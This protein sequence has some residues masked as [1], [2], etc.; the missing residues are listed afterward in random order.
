[1][2]LLFEILTSEVF[3]TAIGA[4][5]TTAAVFIALWPTIRERWTC[6]KLSIAEFE[7]GIMSGDPRYSHIA[8]QVRFGE[9]KNFA[10]YCTG[11]IPF[12]AGK[13]QRI[14][15]FPPLRLLWPYENEDIGAPKAR[16]LRRGMKTYVDLF[17]LNKAQTSFHLATIF[18]S[19]SLKQIRHYLAYE[20]AVEITVVGENYMDKPFYASIKVAENASTS[21]HYE[22][23]F[24]VTEYFPPPEVFK[25]E[26]V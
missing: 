19:E 20:A 23:G 5:S 13:P 9:L 2:C 26:N 24:E 22:S 4:I 16:T 12:I 21:P 18:E 3:W 15:R 1:M 17:K 11:V 7:E 14:K 6:I 10:V 25:E 8:V